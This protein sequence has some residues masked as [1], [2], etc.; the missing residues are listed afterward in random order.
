[1]GRLIYPKTEIGSP[2]ADIIIVNLVG[3]QQVYDQ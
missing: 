1:M 3:L 2:A